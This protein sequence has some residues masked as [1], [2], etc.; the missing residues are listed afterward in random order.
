MEVTKEQIERALKVW[1][2]CK[3]G[4]AT[5]KEAKTELIN[6][7]NEI[8]NTKYKTTSNYSAC[9]NTC[10]QGIKRIVDEQK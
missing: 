1:E 3:T 10:F 9:L 5:T 4:R 7:Y 2:F 8:H 6:L